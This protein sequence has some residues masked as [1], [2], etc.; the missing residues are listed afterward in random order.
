MPDYRRCRIPGGIYFFTVNLLE[1]RS[2][3]LVRHID[4]LREAVRATRKQR[5]FHIDGWV[6]LPDHLHCMWTLP[7]GDVDFSNR[8]KAIKIRFVH[9]IAP[10]ERRSAVR[11]KRGERAIWQRRFWEHAIRDDEDYARH[12]DYIHYNPVKHGW[13]SSVRDWPYSTFHRSVQT[14]IYP[15][16]WA[17]NGNED[18]ACGERG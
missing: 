10:S 5:P 1:R 7:P 11:A 4:S 9:A 8:W 6:V 17:G 16:D 3:F 15:I 12:L 13:A 2:D 14:G 18:L